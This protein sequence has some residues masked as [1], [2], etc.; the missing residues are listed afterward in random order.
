MNWSRLF[1][2][3]E[4]LLENGKMSRGKA[5]ELCNNF[6]F[7]VNDSKWNDL[8]KNEKKELKRIV[9]TNHNRS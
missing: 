7:L 8:E 1:K 6:N 9:L 5:K 2:R 4:K 3:A